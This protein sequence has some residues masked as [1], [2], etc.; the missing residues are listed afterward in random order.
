MVPRVQHTTKIREAAR[1]KTATLCETKFGE[2][3]S[4]GSTNDTRVRKSHFSNVRKSMG[5]TFHWS[6]PARQAFVAY[7]IQAGW[8]A[9]ICDTEADVA[10]TVNQLD[11]ASITTLWRPNLQ[12]QQCSCVQARRTKGSSDLARAHLTALV[13]VSCNDYNNNN[14]F[15]LGLSTNFSIIRTLEEKGNAKQKHKGPLGARIE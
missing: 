2:H 12:R 9:R 14:I 10:I 5:A 13:I 11:Y 7:M 15:S 1:E 3:W 6:L 8:A 4:G